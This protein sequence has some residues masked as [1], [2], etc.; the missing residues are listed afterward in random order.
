[1]YVDVDS[2]KNNTCVC[3]SSIRTQSTSASF[4]RLSHSSLTSILLHRRRLFIRNGLSYR[5][6]YS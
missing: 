4:G 5:Y 2:T 1:M 3:I 6:S